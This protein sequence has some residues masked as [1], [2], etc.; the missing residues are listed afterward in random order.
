MDATR[1]DSASNG[2]RKPRHFIIQVS[3]EF[4]SDTTPS[5]IALIFD[6]EFE[7]YTIDGQLRDFANVP[8]CRVF[9]ALDQ[10]GANALLNAAYDH[11]GIFVWGDD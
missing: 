8:G 10:D 9:E 11:S 2:G 4:Y 6:C 3:G 7:K 5:D 1:N